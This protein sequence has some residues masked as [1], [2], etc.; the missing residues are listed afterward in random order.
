MLKNSGLDGL[1]RIAN[2]GELINNAVN[3]EKENDEPTLSG[4]L[5]D[6]ALVSDI[7]SYDETADAVVLMTIHS[8]KGLE[9]P[10]RVPAQL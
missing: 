5:E 8:A 6:V 4:F 2:V 9:F 3:Y 7:D 1:E 10:G